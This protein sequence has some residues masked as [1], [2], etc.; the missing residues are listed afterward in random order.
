[1]LRDMK[2]IG[3]YL[4]NNKFDYVFYCAID[5]DKNN[6]VNQNLDNMRHLLAYGNSFKKW[7]HMSSRAVYDGLGSFHRVEPIDIH[8]LPMP[9]NNQYSVLKYMEEKLLVDKYCKRSIVLRLFDVSSTCSFQDIK[10]R[11]KEQI[12]KNGI[13]RHEILS[14]ID[15]QS[16]KSVIVHLI[17]GNIS[18]GTYNVC[19]NRTISSADIQYGK[20]MERTGKM[21]FDYFNY[22]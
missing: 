7:V 20:M 6:L 22:E 8:K 14:P 13:C 1:M 2:S 21:S 3:K 18:V 12:R 19:G 15:E 4:G 16:F 10:N 5:K 11:W 17:T 9:V